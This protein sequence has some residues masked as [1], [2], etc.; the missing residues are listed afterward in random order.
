MFGGAKYLGLFSVE[1]A[2]CHS[3][4]TWDFEAA[5][6]VLETV[7]VPGLYPVINS[8]LRDNSGPG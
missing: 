7:C 4:G 5:S 8:R 3:A 6:I 2:L 1:V